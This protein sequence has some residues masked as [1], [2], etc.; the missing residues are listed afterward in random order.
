MKFL[1]FYF[2]TVKSFKKS[3]MFICSICSKICK[4]KHGLMS[5]Y[6]ACKE[7]NND[8]NFNRVNKK[9]KYTYMSINENLSNYLLRF[10]TVNNKVKEF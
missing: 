4:S 10:Q 8:E 1:R 7:I 9:R 5:H 6:N 2:E 3:T